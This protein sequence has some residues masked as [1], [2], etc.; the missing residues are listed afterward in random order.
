MG[1]FDFLLASG[2]KM[3][4]NPLLYIPLY[5]CTRRRLAAIPGN[6]AS[7]APHRTLITH[8]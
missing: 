4:A 3:E 7:T 2:F 5:T 1:C 8:L 6:E